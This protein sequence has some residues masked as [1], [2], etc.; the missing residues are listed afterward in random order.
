MSLKFK[1]LIIK[2]KKKHIS[3]Q[4]FFIFSKAKLKKLKMK[5]L[6]IVSYILVLLVSLNLGNAQKNSDVNITLIQS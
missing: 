5:F 6:E 1:Y 3:K 2:S 4:S